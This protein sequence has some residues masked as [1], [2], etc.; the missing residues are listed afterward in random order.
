MAA[1]KTAAAGTVVAAAAAMLA[2]VLAAGAVGKDPVRVA[3]A[4]VEGCRAG[5]ARSDS[6]LSNTSVLLVLQVG[7]DTQPAAL[8]G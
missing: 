1:A 5:W 4:Q 7:L 6:S 2:H 8:S 3:I